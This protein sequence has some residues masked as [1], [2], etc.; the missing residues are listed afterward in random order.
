MK[1]SI[2]SRTAFS[3]ASAAFRLVAESRVRPTSRLT[4]SPTFSVARAC[5]SSTVSILAA[6]RNRA[7]MPKLR[8]AMPMT[9]R[10]SL[11]A[12]SRMS[13]STALARDLQLRQAVDL[14][15]PKHDA[16]EQEAERIAVGQLRQHRPEP[17]REVAAQILE[18]VVLQGHDPVEE[19]GQDTEFVEVAIEQRDRALLERL[20]ARD[21]VVHA[22]EEP[23]E[24]AARL[25]LVEALADELADVA[26]RE[27]V[28]GCG[29]RLEVRELVRALEHVDE[30][31]AVD[32]KDAAEEVVG[33]GG[34]AFELVDER[35]VDV[36]GNPDVRR[37]VPVH[38]HAR[39]SGM[40]R[41]RR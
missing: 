27:P 29:E 11:C 38:P 21:D 25:Q 14:G 37:P 35:D 19:L 3:S 9:S 10:I 28:D 15:A 31:A 41:P 24:L 18:R 23:G 7:S 33:V 13:A 30:A 1:A 12:S 5:S 2:L 22:P 8:F 17:W 40:A 20:V 39:P 36:G 34:Q 32:A 4:N 26:P 6:S 16:P